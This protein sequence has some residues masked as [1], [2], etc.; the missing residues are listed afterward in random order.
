MTLTLTQ[1]DLTTSISYFDSVLDLIGRT[2]LVRLSRVTRDLGLLAR[3]P[4][5]RPSS[6]C[7]IQVVRPRTG[8]PCA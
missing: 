5:V 4:L 7:S 6:R 3:Q 2:P 1:S 8:S